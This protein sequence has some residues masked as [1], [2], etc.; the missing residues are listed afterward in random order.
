MIQIMRAEDADLNPIVPAHG[1]P[2]YGLTSHTLKIGDGVTT[3]ENLPKVGEALQNEDYKIYYKE[4]PENSNLNSYTESGY[5]YSQS[6][7]I[8]EKPYNVPKEFILVVTNIPDL[9]QSQCTQYIKSIENNWEYVRTYVNDEW[10]PWYSK[11]SVDNNNNLLQPLVRTYRQNGAS[12]FGCKYGSEDSDD[13]IYIH[14]DINTKARGIYDTDA[15]IIVA[16]SDNKPY[17]QGIWDGDPVDVSKGGTGGTSIA[18]ARYNLGVPAEIDIGDGSS[19]FPFSYGSV[20]ARGN[21]GNTIGQS[22]S[23]NY[24]WGVDSDATLWGG[25]QINGATEV[26]WKPAM[27]MNSDE[28]RFHNLFAGTL[29]A[30]QTM[31]LNNGN[32]YAAL[33]IGVTPNSSIIICDLVTVPTDHNL[34]IYVLSRNQNNI[35]EQ[36]FVKVTHL[37]SNDLTIYV[38][39]GLIRYIWGILKYRK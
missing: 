20:V 34:S 1:Q 14:A 11:L 30:G 33:I 26:N 3:W 19:G 17:H 21:L 24:Y 27:M 10:T 7:N 13:S 39:N 35:V 4:I 29:N 6:E 8:T 15:G 2:A 9:A 36:V 31:T 5:Y 22:T 18:D 16:V 12:S 23:D 38:E 32:K 25:S 28:Q 37:N